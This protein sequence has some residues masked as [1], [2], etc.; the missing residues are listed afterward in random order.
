MARDSKPIIVNSIVNNGSLGYAYRDDNSQ[1]LKMFTNDYS[2]AFKQLTMADNTQ[3]IY[4]LNESDMIEKVYGIGAFFK[5]K[6]KPGIYTYMNNSYGCAGTGLNDGTTDDSYDSWAK[7]IYPFDDLKQVVGLN[8]NDIWQVHDVFS[9][10]PGFG[11]KTYFVT[12]DKKSILLTGRIDINTYISPMEIINIQDSTI[13]TIRDIEYGGLLYLLENGKLY[14]WGDNDKNYICS[15]Q[16]KSYVGYGPVLLGED[17]EE[18]YPMANMCIYKK[19][20]RYFFFG[21][22]RDS[23]SK[24]PLGEDARGNVRYPF[25]GQELTHLP[26]SKKENI[27]QLVSLKFGVAVLLHDG[28]LYITGRDQEFNLGDNKT[29]LEENESVEEISFTNG[30]V[31]GY[32]KDGIYYHTSDGNK[33]DKYIYR[34]HKY[35]PSIALL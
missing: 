27:K 25:P 16:D 5:L 23:Y 30:Y 19:D 3:V 6:N 15:N 4:D 2:L 28:Y 1:S 20:N 26:F 35:H 11:L 34:T 9:Y 29:K 14:Y 17:I 8:A 7:T 33:L 32:K 22:C 10:R 21:Y 12:M 13:K 31:V 24:H 18:I